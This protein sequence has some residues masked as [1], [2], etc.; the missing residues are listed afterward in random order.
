MFERA[1]IHAVRYYLERRNV[2]GPTRR[3]SL[4]VEMLPRMLCFLGTEPGIRLYVYDGR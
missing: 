2:D 4:W 1:R 3:R